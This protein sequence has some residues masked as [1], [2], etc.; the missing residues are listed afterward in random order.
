MK[1]HLDHLIEIVPDLLSRKILDLGSG[2]GGFLLDVSSRGGDATGLELSPDYIEETKHR[3]LARG[4][5]VN[6]LRGVAEKMPFLED[7]FDFINICEV[8]EHVNDPKAM[9][10]EVRR[11]LKPGGLAYLS[12]PNRFGMRDQ[13]FGLYFI[14]WVP[15][16]FSRKIIS[17]FSKEDKDYSG[18]IGFQHLDQMHYYT[19]RKIISLTKS[20]SFK[21]SDI[22]IEK[23]KTRFKNPFTQWFFLIVYRFLRSFYFDSFHLLLQK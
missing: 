3:A 11:V 15:R 4:L 10:K 23:I 2:R 9:L 6:V 14:N 1:T 7:S 16:H 13:H 12:V 19:F 5:M 21:V 22:R 17:L 18:N 8:I 20:L